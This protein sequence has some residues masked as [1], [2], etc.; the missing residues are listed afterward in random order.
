ML[1]T[2]NFGEVPI[3]LLRSNLIFRVSRHVN[4]IVRCEHVIFWVG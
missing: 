4:E 1:F 2:L 3:P